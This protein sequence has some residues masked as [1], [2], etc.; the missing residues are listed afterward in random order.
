MT[1]VCMCVCEREHV[2]ALLKFVFAYYAP[3]KAWAPHPSRLGVTSR[4][5]V[6]RHVTASRHGVTSRRHGATSLTIDTGAMGALK[7]ACSK[8][9]PKNIIR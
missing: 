7:M 3:G 5:H 9:P 8:P 1:K 4:R 2:L 6:R